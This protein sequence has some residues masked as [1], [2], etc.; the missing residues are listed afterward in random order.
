MFL[1]EAELE[2]MSGLSRK[3]NRP[4]TLKKWLIETGFREN[5]DFFRR[6]DGWYSLMRPVQSAPVHR[7]KLRL[8][9]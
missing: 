2:Q 9:A 4:S 8:Q 1:T 3:H 7:P 5:V 6:H